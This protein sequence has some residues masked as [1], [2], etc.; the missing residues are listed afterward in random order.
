TIAQPAR[1]GRPPA[2]EAG[3]AD[4]TSEGMFRR[5]TK[6][7]TAVPKRRLFSLLARVRSA[8]A[9][10]G[11]VEARRAAVRR[12]IMALTALVYCHPSQEALMAYM[13]I[14]PELIQELVDLVRVRTDQAAQ[15]TVPLDISVLAVHCLAALVHTRSGAS[16]LGL[17]ARHTHVFQELGITRGQYTGL[18][19]LLV[20]HGVASLFIMPEQ[21][22][23]AAA[24][25]AASAGRSDGDSGVV[26]SKSSD[27]GDGK[28]PPPPPPDAALSLGIAFVEAAG[29]AQSKGRRDG[30]SGRGGAPN[31]DGGGV[32]EEK[33]TAGASSPVLSEMDQLRWVETVFSLVWAVV[34]V[35]HGAAAMTECGLIP[36]L[37]NVV[38]LNMDGQQG[39]GGMG[40][41][42]Q[43]RYVVSQAVQIME[44]A[45]V[46]NAAALSAFRDL[47]AAEVLAS[48]F[49][50]EVGRL[51]DAGAA[52]AAA[53]AAAA[54]DNRSGGSGMVVDD[55]KGKAE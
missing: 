27:P 13:S 7:H 28:S 2:G 26:E 11:G 35:Q 3:D 10:R 21:D 23:A 22:A 9:W 55:P 44:T 12:R 1:V 29:A 45:V 51:R 24:G 52:A 38:Q 20:R 33:G 43:R 54:G 32:K 50:T 41:P 46:N 15:M 49:S 19:P 39:F 40:K 5:L 42:F 53:A 18:L 36:A 8:V 16:S 14:Q 47:G 17:V 30:G 34:S 31:A 6:E 4:S 25:A 37:L 48:A